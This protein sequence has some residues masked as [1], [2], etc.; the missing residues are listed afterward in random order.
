ML[1][2]LPLVAALSVLFLLVVVPY[3][4]RLDRVVS[5]LSFTLFGGMDVEVNRQRERRL[6]TAAIGT[7]Y[8]E[9]ATKTRLYVVGS[10]VATGVVGGYVG[11]AAVEAAGGAGAVSV[12][13]LRIF[14]NAPDLSWL[15]ATV[16]RAIETVSNQAGT[17][18]VT[19]L[20]GAL[21]GVTGGA[22]TYL[23]R[24]NLPSLRA[25]TRRRRIDA[26]MPR[27]V[28]FVYA[29]TR[30]GMAFPDVMRALSRNK[31]V[32]GES[33][34]EMGVGVRSLDLFNVDLVTAVRDISTRT[35]S[36][37]FEKFN[38]NLGSVLQSGGNISEF[39]RD[40]YERYREEAEEQQR[41]ILDV[42]ATTAEVYV[43]VV[44]AS[45]SRISRCCSSA[46]SR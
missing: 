17:A 35:P 44:V 22:T 25:D 12:A 31:A 16:D 41:E 6:R 27:M 20:I 36:T 21:A 28:A 7:P 43:T 37:Q 26:G 8:R 1:A 39:L 33:A 15:P 18:L 24:W 14:S 38:E 11:F 19:G 23:L 2:Y 13:W 3:S 34:A 29:L 45:R 30:G 40:Q 5:R 4:T 42:L 9:Y 32:F 46:S 10:G